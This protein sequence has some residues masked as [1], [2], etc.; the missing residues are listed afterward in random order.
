MTKTT[1]DIAR[2][3]APENEK[4]Y[5]QEL[6]LKAKESY[7][8]EDSVTFKIIELKKK[9]FL[10][11]TK[12]LYAY[13]SLYH[14]A[15]SYPAIDFW[16]H[17][18]DHLIG[19]YFRGK[20]HHI[21]EN[22]ISILINAGGA[23]YDRPDLE[24]STQYH[25]II[26]Q[27]SSYGLFVDLGFHFNWR[28][29]S[30]LGLIHHSSLKSDADYNMLTAGEEITTTFQG[31]TET[32]KII[33]GENHKQGKWENGTMAQLIDTIQ[34]ATVV[35]GDDQRLVFYVLG[36][37][38]AKAPINKLLYPNSKSI[39]KKYRDDLKHG[40]HIKC[41]V[42]RINRKKDSFIIRLFPQSQIK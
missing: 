35:K 34:D 20:I 12:G 7:K 4:S 25:G 14:F 41:K 21:S 19:N 37:H 40:A 2:C 10:V 13:V 18:A 38:Q 22:P 36:E 26:V 3:H 31:Y 6:L 30:I 1:E 29:G 24:K 5:L 15:W 28:F 16:P 23:N 11:K 33:L 8:N 9:G 27:K 39:V 17:V 32:G 42:I